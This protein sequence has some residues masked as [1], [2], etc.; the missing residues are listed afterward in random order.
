MTTPS[1]LDAFSSAILQMPQQISRRRRIDGDMRTLGLRV[2]VCVYSAL[3]EEQPF[4]ASLEV[5]VDNFLSNES[6]FTPDAR[7]LS[8][9]FPL[10][11]NTV[12]SSK[13][14][15]QPHAESDALKTSLVACADILG[16]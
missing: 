7:L 9:S 8:D 2:V 11:G 6:P 3:R 14:Q 10:A 16:E 5:V 15:K 13:S 12:L 1:F 4:S